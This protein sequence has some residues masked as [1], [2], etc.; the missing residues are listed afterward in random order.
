MHFWNPHSF[1]FL[2]RF[3]WR[4]KYTCSSHANSPQSFRV[5]STA[6]A[7]TPTA[8]SF[9]MVPAYSNALASHTVTPHRPMR[10][11]WAFVTPRRPHAETHSR[12]SL[13]VLAPAF[14]RGGLSPASPIALTTSRLNTHATTQHH[15]QGCNFLIHFPDSL[16]SS[17][18]SV[19]FWF[20]GIETWL[21]VATRTNG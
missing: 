11:A 17:L 9:H 19:P 10:C 12:A 1:F 8:Y 2:E 18:A 16:N 14:T 13:L 6:P 21:V 5:L 7:S 3:F 4:I 20:G 15:S